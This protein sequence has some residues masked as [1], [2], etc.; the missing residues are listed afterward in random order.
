MRNIRKSRF[1]TLLTALLI[2]LVCVASACTTVQVEEPSRWEVV[3]EETSGEAATVEEDIAGGEFNAFFPDSDGDFSV[4]YTQEKSGFAEAVLKESGEDVATLA[5]S[6]TANNVSARDKYGDSDLAVGGYPAAAVGSNG[7]A[8]LVA[9]RIQVQV[10]S[11]AES[12]DDA[13]R[14]EWLQAF[15]L[16]GLAELVAEHQASE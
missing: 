4:V 13:A 6:D 12:F 3:Q 9:D 15:D 16:A 2:S 10:R 1:Q 5:V 14:E 11:V 8:V 7:T